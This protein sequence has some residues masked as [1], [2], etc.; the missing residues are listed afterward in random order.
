MLYVNDISRVLPNKNVKLF[1]DGTNL[2]I[3][4]VDVN[5]LNQKCN[6]CIDTLNPWFIAN[7]LHV[8]VDKTKTKANDICAKLNDITVTKI[9]LSISWYIS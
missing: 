5:T 1:A 6:Y 2:F 8:N 9:L 7:L 3:L 4:G